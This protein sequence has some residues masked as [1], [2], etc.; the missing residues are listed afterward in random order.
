MGIPLVGYSHLHTY[1][2]TYNVCFRRILAQ[3]F[4]I[5]RAKYYFTVTTRVELFMKDPIERRREKERARELERNDV[6]IP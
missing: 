4:S 2:H 3:V 1:I 6:I 5:A